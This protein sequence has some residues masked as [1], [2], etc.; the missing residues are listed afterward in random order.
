MV[1]SIWIEEKRV[2]VLTSEV[3]LLCL[4][5]NGALYCTRREKEGGI[6][7]S[8]PWRGA[9]Q[10]RVREGRQDMGP[11]EGGRLEGVDAF[12]KRPSTKGGEMDALLKEPWRK[13]A[14]TGIGSRACHRNMS[15]HVLPNGSIFYQ[16]KESTESNRK[17]SN[18]SL[19]CLLVHDPLYPNS[20]MT[21]KV[22]DCCFP[23]GLVE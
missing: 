1:F 19:K 17:E 11:R 12:L 6:G 21:L 18:L 22:L 15:F 23:M 16:L 2:E 20:T 13:S 8:G 4:G 5:E 9:P 10:G 3:L 7:L 14:C